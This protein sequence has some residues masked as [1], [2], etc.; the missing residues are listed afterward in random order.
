MR[1]VDRNAL[2]PYSAAQMYALVDDVETYPEFLPW[3]TKAELQSRVETELIASLTIGYGALNSAFTTRN[4]L[5]PPVS[6]TMELLDGPFSRLEGRWEFEPL[7]DSGCEVNLR[8]EFEF[9][10]TLQDMLFGGIFETICNEL[11]GAFIKRAHAIYGKS[12]SD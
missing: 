4:R 1:I 5:Q 3:C 6:M 7:D 12:G 2:V 11:I 9:A 10:S 8:V